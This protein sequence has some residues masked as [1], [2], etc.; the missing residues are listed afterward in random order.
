MRWVEYKKNR[1]ERARIASGI[2]LIETWTVVSSMITRIQDVESGKVRPTKKECRAM[3]KMYGVQ[4][5]WLANPGYRCSEPS[6][7]NRAKRSDPVVHSKL[8][9]R[10]ISGEIKRW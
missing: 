8:S 1:F 4:Y 7:V 3:A 5:V 2:A 10:S 9:T 6:T